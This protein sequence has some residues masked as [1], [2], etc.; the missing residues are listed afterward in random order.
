MFSNFVTYWW[1]YLTIAVVSYFFGSIN[2]SVI[3]SRRLKKRDIRTAGSG[4]AGTTNMFRTF[5]P[6]MGVL[7][8]VFDFLKGVLPCL[9]AYL[10]TLY[11]G[12]F[13]MDA[14]Q[15]ALGVAGVFVILGHVFPIYFG[16][17]GGKGFAS[18]LG[19]MVVLEP[20]Y[21]AIGLVPFIILLIILDRMSI[22]AFLTVSVGTAIEWVKY[23]S[24]NLP[25]CLCVTLIAVI[26]FFAHR[27]NIVRLVKGK[28]LPMGLRKRIFKKKQT[29]SPME[30]QDIQNQT[31]EE[32]SDINKDT[33]SGDNDQL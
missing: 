22:M 31:N 7:A 6:W 13:A 27:S 21:I 10:L 29:A 16:F 33:G 19:F 11:V 8:F 32:N 30:Q 23:H 12:N 18:F 17:K 26:V 2:Y 3:F 28:E 15:L 20:L 4:N 25:L 5:G 9:T 1:Q 24:T 14:A